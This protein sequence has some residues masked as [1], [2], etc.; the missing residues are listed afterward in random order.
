MK[1]TLLIPLV[2]PMQAWGS[3]SR[4]DDRDT[5]PEPTKS[6]VIGLI[7]AALGRP[8]TQSL[9]DLTAL[10]FGVRIDAQGTMQ[11]DFHT[12]Q[13][14]LRASGAG[15]T[16]VTS[17]RHYISDARFLAGLEG[18][19]H[20]QLQAIEAA[21]RNPK[22]SLALGRKSLVLT[23]PPFLPGGSVRQNMRLE[24]AL[25]SEPWRCL[26][27]WDK[28]SERLRVL[29]EAPD[30]EHGILQDNPTSFSSRTFGLR[31]VTMD[32]LSP[33]SE[34]GTWCTYLD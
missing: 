19:D 31:R 33:V 6:G 30:G 11:T 8:R 18:D 10:R 23:L 34:G 1:H 26:W 16:A 20:D 3:R 2:G 4:F 17:K 9:D 24:E 21:L 28:P 27:R 5:H 25:S 15:T 13:E 22:W 7:C 12:A 32:Y 29:I 14:V